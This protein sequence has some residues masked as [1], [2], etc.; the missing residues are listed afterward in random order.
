M[1]KFLLGIGIA[2][3][4]LGVIVGFN[5]LVP[6]SYLGICTN[7]KTHVRLPDKDCRPASGDDGWTY[8]DSNSD[9]PAVGQEADDGAVDAPDQDDQVKRGGVPEQGQEAVNNNDDNNSN[10]GGDFEPA[11]GGSDVGVNS[12]DEGGDENAGSGGGGEDGE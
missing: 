10:P 4:V 7:T 5:Y 3:A 12:G 8:Y 1:R 6:H 2:V 11:G 9:I